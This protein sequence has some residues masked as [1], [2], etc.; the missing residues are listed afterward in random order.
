MEPSSGAR[1]VLTFM[2]PTSSVPEHRNGHATAM[3]SRNQ[4]L[5]MR[6]PGRVGRG[7]LDWDGGALRAPRLM[8]AQIR[9]QRRGTAE[10]VAQ[11]IEPCGQSMSTD[12]PGQQPMATA[13][14]REQQAAP[15]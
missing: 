14:V 1:I 15:P 9:G 12:E 7:R 6:W 3:A 2:S 13:Q 4:R 5:A 11:A 10:A 8:R